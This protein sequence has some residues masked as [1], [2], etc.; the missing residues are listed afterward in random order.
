MSLNRLFERQPRPA[1]D[2]GFGSYWVVN[3][4]APPG[5]KRPRKRGRN[6]EARERAAAIAAGAGAVSNA[7]TSTSTRRRGAS[8]SIAYATSGPASA[9]Y[10]HPPIATLR[11]VDSRSFSRP[12]AGR[13]RTEYEDEYEDE[14]EDEEMAYDTGDGDDYESEE[15][16]SPYY[17]GTPPHYNGGSP[18]YNGP[19]HP[20][21]SSSHPYPSVQPYY[22][23]GVYPQYD[24]RSSYHPPARP[25]LHGAFSGYSSTNMDPR[26]ATVERLKMEM[27]GL[28]RQSTDA[29][30]ASSRLSTQLAEIQE[31]NMRT[32]DALKQTEQ[33]L[34]EEKKH[35]EEVER[36]FQS[37]SRKREALEQKLEAYQTKRRPPSVN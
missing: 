11:P 37:E 21:A 8:D 6:R 33:W 4:E 16:A 26:D 36:A 24:P 25:V 22:V 34:R 35:R 18:R 32:R 9:R 7:S 15:G 2:P 5:T 1:T 14:D 3:L 17:G 12:T 30:A 20:Y 10:E 28:R 31:E 19:S 23:G 13:V 29:V 27:A